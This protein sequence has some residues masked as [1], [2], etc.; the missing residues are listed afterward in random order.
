MNRTTAEIFL[1]YFYLKDRC[2]TVIE[3]KKIKTFRGFVPD[4][5]RWCLQHSPASSCHFTCL[6]HVCVLFLKKTDAPIFFCIISW[7][8]VFNKTN[9]LLHARLMS[10]IFTLC[11]IIFNTALGCWI[12][13]RRVTN[14]LG[15]KFLILNKKT[16]I[17]TQFFGTFYV[18]NTSVLRNW[19]FLRKDSYLF[20][21]WNQF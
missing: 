20:R 9:T 3:T 4:P 11:K 12:Y 13:L 15:D 14:Y 16:E 18:L 1:P 7:L 2:F 17:V 6:W 5:H 19:L 8:G 21:Y 10:E